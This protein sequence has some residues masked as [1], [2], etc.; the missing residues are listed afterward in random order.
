[1]QVVGHPDWHGLQAGHHLYRG[2]LVLHVHWPGSLPQVHHRGVVVPLAPLL[3]PLLS[4]LGLG[5]LLQ[6][7][8]QAA[9]LHVGW[10]VLHGFHLPVL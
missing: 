6:G 4:L 1:M 2:V 3:W 9:Y 10:L 5:P 7:Y 8:P